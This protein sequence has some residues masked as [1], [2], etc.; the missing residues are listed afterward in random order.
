MLAKIVTVVGARPQFIKA[1][2]VC[3]ALAH[4]GI[5]EFLVHTGQH[6]DAVMSQVFF[7]EL[8][9]PEPDL[10][11]GVG[12]GPPGWQTSQMLTGLEKVL[13]EQRP[14]LV[15]VYGDTNS[16]LAGSLAALKMQLPLAHVEAGLRS[17]NRSMPEEHNRVLTDHAADLLFC[18]T[19]TAVDN[20]ANEGITEGVHL[21]GDTM[22]D[23]V[24]A[25][26]EQLGDASRLASG[27]GLE[28]EAYAVCTLHRPYNVDDPEVFRDI[29]QAIGTSPLPVVFPVHP[30]TRARLEALGQDYS[31]RQP[32]LILTEPL[33]YLDMLAL[34]RGSRLVLTDSGGLQKEAYFL[35][36]PCLTIR[37]ETEWLE[38]LEDGWNTVLGSNG[39]GIHQAILNC[40]PA[41]NSRR[42]TKFGDGHASEKIVRI[43]TGV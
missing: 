43:L 5:E 12:S 31:K 3:K 38:T 26:V 8:K 40:R 25:F 27:L 42:A 41:A 9:L 39:S 22:L 4:T 35:G 18:P 30:R 16:T 23:A 20:L 34:V 11:L 13:T 7:S 19:P 29:L 14:D 37:P 1:F 15:L 6:Y 2:P 17:F 24:L 36:R 10:N 32:S 21:V 33:G 28:P